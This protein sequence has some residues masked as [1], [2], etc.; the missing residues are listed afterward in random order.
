[1]QLSLSMAG[2]LMLSPK[3][4]IRGDK[5]SER[6]MAFNPGVEIHFGDFNNQTI[7]LVRTHYSFIGSTHPSEKTSIFLQTSFVH[8]IESGNNE[9]FFGGSLGFKQKLRE[10]ISLSYGCSIYGIKDASD[11]LYQLGIGMT[12]RINK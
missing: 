8:Q 6:A 5:D 9:F 3:F 12:F 11:F 1:M 2:S 10:T 7:V 4:Q